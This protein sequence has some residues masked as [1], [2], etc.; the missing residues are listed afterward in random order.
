MKHDAHGFK[1]DQPN[2]DSWKHRDAGAAVTLVTAEEATAHMID[3]A[4]S[5]DESI[6]KISDVDVILVEGFKDADYP[7]IVCTKKEEALDLDSLKQV[8]GI[9][10]FDAGIHGYHDILRLVSEEWFTREQLM[11]KEQSRFAISKR[12]LEPR[13][14]QAV[15][16]HEGAGAVVLFCG[17]VREWTKGKRTLRLFY[18]A[19]PEMAIRQLHVIAAEIGE[20]W[21]DVR[22]AIHHRV[23]RLEIGE[24][25]VVIAT[26]SP[27]RKAAYEANEYAIERMK[28]IVPIWKKEYWEDGE[29]WVG[30]QLGRSAYPDG[31]PNVGV[32]GEKK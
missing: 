1:V 2:T 28:Q 8:I 29:V 22:I 16:E 5:L 21:N 31:Q 14:I 4:N 17:T 19:Y 32:I 18:E 6:A 12:P 23:G 30:D 10:E 9:I 3:Q 27:H 13:S 20:R 26:S 11:I 25:A 24:L 15:V 7:K